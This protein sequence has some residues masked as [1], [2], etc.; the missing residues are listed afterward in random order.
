M[1]Y[2]L[3]L[4]QERLIYS[5]ARALSLHPEFKLVGAIDHGFRERETFKQIYKLPAYETLGQALA[6][7][8]VDLVVLATP[9]TTHYEQ[10]RELLNYCC[11]KV[12][13]CEKPLSY[14]IEESREMLE[15]CAQKG[16]ALYVNYMRR[17]EPG[18]I[19]VKYRIE[20]N[21]IA[22]TVKGI[23]WYSKGFLHNG[24]H[25]FNLLEDWL[26]KMRSFA[27]I[28]NGQSLANGDAEP[29]VRV[30]FEKGEVMFMAAKNE[31]FS[32]NSIELVAENGRLRYENG[33]RYIQWAPIECDKEL[34][35]YAF[36]SQALEEIPSGLNRYQ[37][38]VLDQLAD[39]FRK[40][41]AR[42]CDG[43]QAIQTLESMHSILRARG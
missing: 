13:L 28:D 8:T 30:I 1:G 42:L 31:Q 17:S 38:F 32:L 34:K 12:V 27:L 21:E 35:D 3:E 2:D 18:A 9:T 19:E 16:V 22:G 20:R 36:L 15:L 41:T 10:L 33:G 4:S 5:H 25:L 11:P 6:N 39:A 7:Q 14:S 37:H 26:G 43:H 23:V 24:S 40:K 29:N